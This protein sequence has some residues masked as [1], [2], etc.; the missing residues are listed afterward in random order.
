MTKRPAPPALVRT[1]ASR[2]CLITIAAVVVAAGATA[3][4]V[5]VRSWDGALAVQLVVRGQ[6]VASWIGRRLAGATDQLGAVRILGQ[7]SAGGAR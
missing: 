3:Y 5:E 1:F 2:F 4:V 6:G 7:L